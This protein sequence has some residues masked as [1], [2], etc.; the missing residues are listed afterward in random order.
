V[1]TYERSRS[2]RIKTTREIEFIFILFFE[3]NSHGDAESCGR[4]RKNAS[5]ERDDT[6]DKTKWIM[7]IT[8]RL[9]TAA[10]G[11]DNRKGFVLGEK[12]Y[13][14]TAVRIKQRFK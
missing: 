10:K 3:R 2:G 1:E 8:F 9:K 12:L 14:E 7:S 11:G 6:S 4:K 5:S 13:R